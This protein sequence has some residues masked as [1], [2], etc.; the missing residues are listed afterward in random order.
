MPLS[1]EHKRRRGRNMLLGAVLVGLVVL[2]YV[3]TIVKLK[4]GG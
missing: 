2:F 4:T 1:Q 3:L